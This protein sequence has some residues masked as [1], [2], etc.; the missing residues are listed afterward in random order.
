MSFI[1]PSCTRPAVLLSHSSPRAHILQT[2]SSSHSNTHTFHLQR[3][4]L[5][6]PL[7]PKTCQLSSTGSSLNADFATPGTLQH[8]T[9]AWPHRPP[10]S[11]PP[12]SETHRAFSHLPHRSQ[13]PPHQ[14]EA[15]SHLFTLVPPGAE[16]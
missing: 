11:P 8:Q 10:S 1:T 9:S 6:F 5:H 2:H 16:G 15:F 4:K 14:T 13:I 12:Q 7:Y 3:D